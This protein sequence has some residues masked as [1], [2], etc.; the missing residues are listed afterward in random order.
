MASGE[1][2]KYHFNFLRNLL[3]KTAA[4]LGYKDWFDLLPKNER[5]EPD[6]FG[7]RI[8]SLSSHSDHATN[9]MAQVD[10]RD[11]S[12]LA[13]LLRHVTEQYKFRDQAVRDG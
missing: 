4:F 6:G 13:E 11:A 5:Y 8:I 2:R 3:E 1:V 10:E 9:E 12:K 7:L